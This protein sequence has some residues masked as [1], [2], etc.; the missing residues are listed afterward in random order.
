MYPF[1]CCTLKNVYKRPSQS[2]DIPKRFNPPY[3]YRQELKICNEWKFQIKGRTESAF[4]VHRLLIPL[5]SASY[6]SRSISQ[7]LISGYSHV[8]TAFDLGRF[9]SDV[10]EEWRMRCQCAPASH[11][12]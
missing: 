1:T 10:R 12:Q 8:G 4:G 5:K 3:T 7:N 11:H 2:E 9:L 6:S